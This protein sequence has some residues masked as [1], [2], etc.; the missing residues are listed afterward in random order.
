MKLDVVVLH[1]KIVRTVRSLISLK[2]NITTLLFF[3]VMKLFESEG[4]NMIFSS[5][6]M[7]RLCFRGVISVLMN[8]G[9]WI[10]EEEREKE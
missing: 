4:T 10:D 7:G 9:S 3:L 2:S 1:L 6:S 5:L 8:K